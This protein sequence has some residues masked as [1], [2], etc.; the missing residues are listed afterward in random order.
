MRTQQ[1]QKQLLQQIAVNV[2]VPVAEQQGNNDLNIVGTH[3]LAGQMPP[4]TSQPFTVNTT[5]VP[6]IVIVGGNGGGDSR[7]GGNGSG[8]S[9]S[10]STTRSSNM[11]TRLPTIPSFHN[12]W[13]RG[14]TVY[15]TSASSLVPID[16]HA[17][18]MYAKKFTR[19]IPIPMEELE[20]VEIIVP[21][22]NCGMVGSKEYLFYQKL[23]TEPIDHKFGVPSHL[24]TDKSVAKDGDQTWHLF[25][26][27]QY[28]DTL[29][30][31]EAVKQQI[32]IVEY[33]MI[34]VAMVPVGVHDSSA[35]HVADMFQY[36]N[37]HI[38]TAW[39]TISSRTACTY[40]WAINI[41][42]SDEDQFSS[43]WLKILLY[44][45]CTTEMKEVLMLEYG[46]LDVCFRGGVTF[47]WMLC[48]KLFGLNR[49]TIA[50]LVK[51]LKLFWNKGLHCY[52]SENVALAQKELLAVCS[53]LVEAKELTHENASW[54][55]DRLDSLLAW[56]VQDSFQT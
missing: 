39:N 8:G 30:K 38:L 6:T 34:D 9:I 14:T 5:P 21:K 2:G 13:A 19:A 51:F 26:Q 32:V 40:Q 15:S 29:S 50:A 48:N 20:E 55:A 43:K 16:K 31:I 1:E 35:V 11:S 4:T 49:D 56:S 3:G 25:I 22:N 33:D 7:G 28:V 24:V 10:L 54:L 53:R 27:Q 42:M 46:N 23:A 36:D 18:E 44:E 47:A 52:Q 37:A 12:L 41:A 45:S 17:Y